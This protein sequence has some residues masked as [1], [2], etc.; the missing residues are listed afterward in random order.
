MQPYKYGSPP[1]KRK[2]LAVSNDLLSSRKSCPA[3]Y[4]MMANP[5]K[6]RDT[7]QQLRVSSPANDMIG[8][9][10]DSSHRQGQRRV[11]MSNT[12]SSSSANIDF[13]SISKEEE[14]N[15]TKPFVTEYNHLAKKVQ[16]SPL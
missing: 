9:N 16:Y 13:I 10:A 2:E 5:E 14:V 11:R 1:L 3:L 4:S 7:V 8:T 6:P 15:D 12:W